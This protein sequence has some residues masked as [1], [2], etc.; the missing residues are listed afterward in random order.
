M[1]ENAAFPIFL[2]LLCLLSTTSVS[3]HPYLYTCT[4][5]SVLPTLL[6]LRLAFR[7]A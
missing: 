4:S 7:M 2:Q 3:A 6:M 1:I 5:L